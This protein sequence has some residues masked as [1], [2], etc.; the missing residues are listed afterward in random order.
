[1]SD[2]NF[3]RFVGQPHSLLKK[4]PTFIHILLVVTLLFYGCDPTKGTKQVEEIAKLPGKE[5]EEY[6]MI[7]PLLTHPM[8]VNHDQ[9]AF[10]KW[11]QKM[12]VKTT[13]LGTPDWDIPAQIAIIE[14]ETASKPTGLL[15][16]GTDP[17]IAI[18]IDRAVDAGIPT[19]VYDSDIPSSKRHSFLGTD[20][21]EMGQI[22][23]E[24]M[25]ELLGGKGKIACLG[26][27]GLNN[28]ES[29]F[30]GV[31]EVIS[32]YP[33][34]EFIGKFD[35]KANVETSVRITSDLISAHPDLSGI[36]TFTPMS[37]LGAAIAIKEAG[38]AGSIKLTS[39]NYEPE[40]LSL[41]QEGVIQLLVCQKRELFTWY[42]AEFL[43]NMAHGLNMITNNERYVG[44]SNIPYLVNTGTFVVT[45]DNIGFFFNEK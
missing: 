32:E 35:D 7:S 13:I 27:L 42:G 22:Q 29:G 17:A 24:K 45:Q 30:Q 33:V 26:I 19:V 25:V 34:M 28:Q 37:G 12:G 44:I 40:L 20:W 8:Y 39:V 21:L 5:D 10:T 41:L 4:D 23:G 38:K 43:Y 18:A 15:I 6:I 9:A 36:C 2:N 31:Q 1:M 11:G 3:E 14:Q 16:N